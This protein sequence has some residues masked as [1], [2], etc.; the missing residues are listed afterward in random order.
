MILR[1]IKSFIKMNRSRSIIATFYRIRDRFL[2]IGTRRRKVAKFF[3]RLPS[4]FTG[5]NIR[6]SLR[7]YKAHGFKSLLVK[8]REKINENMPVV[9][10][11]MEYKNQ[12]YLWIEKNEP[13]YDDLKKQRETR[14]SYEP[15]ISII[16]PTFNTPEQFLKDMLDSVLNQTY[17]NWELCIADGGSK[18]GLVRKILKDYSKKDERIRCKFL[19]ENKGIAGNLNEALALADGDFIAFLDHDDTLAP[20]ALYEVLM[21]INENP[22]AD[23]IYS[24]EDKITEDS[25]E[26]SDPHFKPG[27]APDTMLCYNYICHLS[28]IRKALVDEVGGFRHGYDGS[29][30]YDLFLRILRK[31]KKIVHIPKI[32]YHWRMHRSSTAQSVNAKDYAISS[33]KKA[34]RDYL[35][36]KGSKADVSDGIVYGT[37]RVSYAI[38]GTPRVSIIIPTKDKVDILKRCVSSIIEK[39]GYPNYEIMIVDNGSKDPD[40]AK[41]YDKIKEDS[42]ILI[43]TYGRPFNFSAIN[44]YAASQTNAEYLLFLN[45]D[46]EVINGQWLQEMLEFA[47]R[48]DVGTVGAKLYYPGGRIQHAGVI[49]GLGGVAG[50]SHKYFPREANGYFTRLKIIQN[51]SAVTAACMMIRKEVFEEVGGFDKNYSHAFNDVDLCMKIREKGYLVI[52]TPYAELYHHES[53]SRGYEDT[54][55][56]RKRYRKEI[57]LFKQK[58]GHV[59]IKGDP[60]YSPNLTLD[61]ADFSINTGILHNSP[62]KKIKDSH[63]RHHLPGFRF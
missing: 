44:N 59:L 58:W 9:L 23:F 20:F 30:D 21:A 41:Y 27:W 60:Y 14:F 34:I 2:P 62:S 55:E 46:T 63:L 5:T 11:S 32:L 45:N 54:P 19:T 39:T 29:Q 18:E 3:F 48:K 36:E 37:Y 61:R 6:E 7:Y 38:K 33:A 1:G 8:V 26:R 13:K 42:R 56:K 43:K 35:S 17:S 12:Y 10:N 49:I 24:D 53:L 25:E 22:D 51:L 15:K 47:Q 28:V 52:Y 50:H 4:M 40:T 16:V 57:E 31:T